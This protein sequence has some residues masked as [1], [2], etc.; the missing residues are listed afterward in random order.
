MDKEKKPDK[1]KKTLT[2]PLLD[3]ERPNHNH[4]DIYKPLIWNQAAGFSQKEYLMSV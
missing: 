2:F 1:E 3:R 4:P